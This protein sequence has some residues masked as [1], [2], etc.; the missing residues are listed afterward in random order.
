MKKKN[1]KTK[2]KPQC[3]RVNMYFFDKRPKT[4]N[5]YYFDS[6]IVDLKKL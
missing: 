5:Q 1:Q 4:F 6:A 2:T 3:F